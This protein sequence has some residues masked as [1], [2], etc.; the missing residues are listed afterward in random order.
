M[1]RT[2]PSLKIPRIDCSKDDAVGAIAGLR[3]KLSPGGDVVSPRGRERTVA[4]FGEALT[5]L[6]V[7]DRILA[8]VRERGLDA[9]LDYTARLDGTQLDRS[10][11]TV[12]REEMAEAYRQADRSYLKTV[13]RVRDNILA[14]QS[15]ILLRDATM[16]P[17]PG[18]ELTLRYRPMRRVGVCVPGG[19]A[20]YPSSLLMTVVPAQ[21]AGVEEI[22]VVVPPTEFGG[23]NA[24]LLAACHLLGVTEVHRIGGAQ[25][26][27]ALAYGVEGIP[28][29]DKIVGPGNLFVAL[30]K[31]KVYGEVDIDS[32]AGP[33]EVVLVA[34]WTAEP[35]FVA[36]DLISQAEH[37]PGSAILITWEP[38]LIDRVAEALEF[39][40][41]RLS[42]GD[43]ARDSL[44]QFGAL[45]LVRDED[46]AV[47]LIN[48][49]AP[50]HLHVSTTDAHRLA[51]R[52]TDAGA[53]FLGH[54]TPVAVGDYAAGP[55]HVLPTGGTARWASGLC[56]NDF[57]KRS[58]LIHVDRVGLERLAPDVRLLADKEGLTG[59]RYSVDV[60][61]EEQDGAS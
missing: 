59:H 32:I 12:S 41:A 3:A 2:T 11:V 40:L 16:R 45:I 25:A 61:L 33:S 54:L 35:S 57:L 39:Q 46:E 10:T 7:V 31:Q 43:L 29:V 6:Q 36:A 44:E 4:V 48:R 52:L 50:E 26:V 23:Y 55:S 17:S 27:G 1:P 20:A 19:A 56:S 13:K 42:R 51:A 14:F 15:G 28:Q 60:R 8:D 49:F 58:S 47:E 18:V 24:D 5:P 53:I 34:D 22:A 38:D 9:V 21:A 30:A 37:S